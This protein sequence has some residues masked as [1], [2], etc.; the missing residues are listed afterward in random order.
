MHIISSLENF[1]TRVGPATQLEHLTHEAQIEG[2]HVESFRDEL[3]GAS[4]VTID[5]F[6]QNR[7]EFGA[8]GRLA[9]AATL[10]PLERDSLI[11]MFNPSKVGPENQKG[12]A[13]GWHKYF[14]QQLRLSS[15]NWGGGKLTIITYNYDRSLEHYLFTILKSTCKKSQQRT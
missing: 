5:R 11:P 9:I 2:Y 1:P 13:E 7:P 8:I 3:A 10:I 4:H 6:L 14:A 15:T 12:V